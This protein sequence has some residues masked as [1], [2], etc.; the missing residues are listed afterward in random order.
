MDLRIAFLGTPDFG[1]PTLIKLAENH[2]VVGVVSQPDRPTGRGRKLISP[3]IIKTAEELGLVVFQTDDVNTP[4]SLEVIQGWRVDLICVAAFGQILKTELLYLPESGC[5]NV[6]ASLLPRWRG[7]S[8]INAAILAGDSHSG[9]TIMKMGPG[10]DD[11]PVLTQESTPIGSEETAGELSD[12]LAELG[13]ELLL[14]TIPLYMRGELDPQPQDPDLAT[15]TRMLRKES[16]KL[17]FNQSA[18]DLSRKVRAYSP[19]PGTFTTW[20]NK[21]LLIHKASNIPVTSPGAGVFIKLEGKPAIGTGKGVL[22]LETLQLAGK[23]S[24]SGEEFLN[25]TPSW[26]KPSTA[27]KKE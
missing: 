10:L 19:W 25:G 23:R 15:Y 24:V 18:D 12:R 11:G 27:E 21:R 20:E 7:A 1:I 8:P 2:K 22:V 14:K 9:V 5:L 26:G 16:G 3:P 4:S 17:D 6:H 13:S